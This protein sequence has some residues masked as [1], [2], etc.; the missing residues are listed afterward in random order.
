M[1]PDTF[2]AET[3]AEALDLATEKQ[4]WTAAQ[5]F[6]V[7]FS[8]ESKKSRCQSLEEDWGEGNAK[9]PEVQCQVATVSDGLGC[10]VS[11]RCFWFKSVLTWG[12]RHL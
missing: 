4:H 1:F 8:H 5:W 12:M 10:H 6:E 9:M 2:E 3:V 7:L 11:C